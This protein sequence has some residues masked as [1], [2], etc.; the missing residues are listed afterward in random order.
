MDCSPP[1]SSV[2]R[3]LQARILEWVAISFSRGSSQPLDWT[4]VSHV[5]GRHFTVWA[6]REVWVTYTR[7]IKLRPLLYSAVR[8]TAALSTC[9]LLANCH[10]HPSSS[11]EILYLLNTGSPS[12]LRKAWKPSF[13]SCLYE[14]DY[15]RNDSTTLFVEWLSFRHFCTESLLFWHHL[16]ESSPLV[17]WFLFIFCP[18]ARGILVPQPGIRCTPPVLEVWSLNHWATREVPNCHKL[19][20]L[21]CVHG[22]FLCFLTVSIVYYFILLYSEM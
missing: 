20:K 5:A 18:V 19:F 13:T 8:S 6:P 1:G 7:N 9:E 2:H 4:Q 12:S 14:S 10:R 15:S 16:W 21:V 3:I 22:E 11:T 17:Y